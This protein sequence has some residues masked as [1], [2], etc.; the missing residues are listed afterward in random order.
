MST[1]P[2]RHAM[3]A[4]PREHFLP[5][6]QKGNAGIDAALPLGGGSTCSQP[7]TVGDM[8]D[9]LQVRPGDRDGAAA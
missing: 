2:V 5:E 6:G 9:L 8:L 4:V 3:A 1:D 7:T